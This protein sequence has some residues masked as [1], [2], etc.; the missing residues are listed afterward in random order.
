[1]SRRFR[2]IQTSLYNEITGLQNSISVETIS[3]W[4]SQNVL[5]R[6]GVNTRLNL[7]SQI[8]YERLPS[9]NEAPDS[10]V[11][12]GLSNTLLS[13]LRAVE[14]KEAP[15]PAPAATRRAKHGRRHWLIAA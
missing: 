9:R 3:T 11:V 8:G 14:D 13:G 2:S 1:M 5:P 4:T 15:P 7:S 12:N 10:A 6:G